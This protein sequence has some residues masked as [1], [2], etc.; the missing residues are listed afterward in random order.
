MK[1]RCRPDLLPASNKLVWPASAMRPE[2]EADASCGSGDES[3]GCVSSFHCDL[4][5]TSA[6]S[7]DAVVA[8]SWQKYLVS[9]LNQF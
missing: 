8:N 2:L 7:A 6:G 4:R 3:G 9:E 5:L 1:S